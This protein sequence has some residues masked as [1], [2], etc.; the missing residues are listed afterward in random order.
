VAAGGRGE[1]HAGTF[2]SFH[3]TFP[4]ARCGDATRS[5]LL[6]LLGGGKAEHLN[7][8]PPLNDSYACLCTAVKNFTH[9]VHSFITL[10]C[11]FLLS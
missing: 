2:S 6:H 7:A 3:D 10:L 1:Q 9:D 5:E 4:P 8:A 11:C